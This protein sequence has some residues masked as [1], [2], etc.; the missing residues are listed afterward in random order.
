MATK[1]VIDTEGRKTL[2]QFLRDQGVAMTLAGEA[3]GVSNVTVLHWRT[4]EKRPVDHQRAKIE[5]WTGGAVPAAAWRTDEE[6]QEI[7]RI[8]PFVAPVP[9][10]EAAA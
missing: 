6:R 5:A 7:E 1:R 2:D 8:R 10:T 9:A 3:L 4:G